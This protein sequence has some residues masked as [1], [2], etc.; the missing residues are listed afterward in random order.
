M[1]AF[2]DKLLMFKI[3]FKI[4]EIWQSEWDDDLSLYQKMY[5]EGYSII[6]DTKW[7]HIF[8]EDYKSYQ[9][10][11]KYFV[12]TGIWRFL[13]YLWKIQLELVVNSQ[14]KRERKINSTFCKL[15]SPQEKNFLLQ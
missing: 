4:V 5:T 11:N 13:L 7:S 15:H 1:L 2:A 12:F 3:L 6:G 9:V 14:A 10:Q 8:E